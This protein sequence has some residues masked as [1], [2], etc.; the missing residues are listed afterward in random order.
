M[1]RLIEAARRYRHYLIAGAIMAAGVAVLYGPG[2]LGSEES[3]RL[4]VTLGGTLLVGGLGYGFLRLDRQVSDDPR[5]RHR[6]AYREHREGGEERPP[7][8]GP[9]DQA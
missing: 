2:D 6:P 7:E 3:N 4:F 8:P 5:Y 9:G 1:N